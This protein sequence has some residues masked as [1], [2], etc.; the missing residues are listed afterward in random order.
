MRGGVSVDGTGEA[1]ERRSHVLVWTADPMT[2]PATVIVR[3]S[4]RPSS[5][6]C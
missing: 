6:R 3:P 4:K 2:R 1:E 5:M